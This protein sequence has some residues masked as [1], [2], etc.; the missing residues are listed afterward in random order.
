MDQLM[1]YCSYMQDNVEWEWELSSSRNNAQNR[2]ITY[3][4]E[5]KMRCWLIKHYTKTYAKA[6][7]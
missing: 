7:A 5:V 1:N 6:E 2:S 4:A 3:K